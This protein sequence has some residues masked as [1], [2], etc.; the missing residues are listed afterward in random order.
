MSGV[1]IAGKGSNIEADQL[2]SE[3][4]ISTN[5]N[6]ENSQSQITTGQQL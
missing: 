6:S 3:P 4:G 5:R 1:I 2:D